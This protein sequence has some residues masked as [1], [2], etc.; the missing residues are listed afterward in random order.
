MGGPKKSWY[1][2]VVLYP[3]CFA[4]HRWIRRACVL[5]TGVDAYGG[6][7]R[8]DYCLFL[9]HRIGG[10]PRR[11][12]GGCPSSCPRG[13]NCSRASN[14][15]HCHDVELSIWL[16]CSGNVPSRIYRLLYGNWVLLKPSGLSLPSRRERNIGRESWPA[17]QEWHS[18]L[19][20]SEWQEIHHRAHDG[21]VHI[22][23]VK[24]ASGT[25]IEFQ[26][27]TFTPQERDRGKPFT[28]P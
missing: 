8:N 28:I 15:R 10:W 6:N 4:V 11:V 13:R 12:R 3:F 5:A 18:V 19:L 22:A 25:V 24:T 26:H 16:H 20:P 1:T 14:Q 7:P 23:D 17:R 2:D 9:L 27:S 21:E